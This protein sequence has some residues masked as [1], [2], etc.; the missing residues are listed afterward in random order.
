MSSDNS[1]SSTEMNETATSVS[2]E[3]LEVSKSSKET[4][5]NSVKVSEATE[6]LSQV[7][8]IIEDGIAHFKLPETTSGKAFSQIQHYISDELKLSWGDV[9]K[10]SSLEYTQIDSSKRYYVYDVDK[11]IESAS[12]LS[13]ISRESLLKQFKAWDH[14]A[15]S[16]SE[17]TMAA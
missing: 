8:A 11:V 1:K 6:E 16:H 17:D 13:G 2:K 4:K 15:G 3:I 10:K 7:N 9:C 5:N 12:T 14:P